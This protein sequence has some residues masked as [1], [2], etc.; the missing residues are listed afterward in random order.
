M[1][2]VEGLHQYQTN[3]ASNTQTM[4]NVKEAGAVRPTAQAQELIPGKVF[5]GMVTEIKNG[6][7][8]LGLSDGRT[9]S[10]RMEA[11]VA[12]E[13]GQPMLFEV[14]ANTGEQIAI[15]PV[16]LESAQNPTLLKALEAAGLK[17]NPRNLSMVNQMMMEQLPID[18][19]SLMQM[20]R[21]VSSFPQ[22][23]MQTL[24]QMQ[25]LGFMI[26]ENSLNQFQN[27]Q[28][29]QQAIL[30]QMQE[31]MEGITNLPEQLA[32][33]EGV[34]QSSLLT[35][36]FTLNP[37]SQNTGLASLGQN[38]S[39]GQ[40][41]SL[42][43]QILAVLTGGDSKT[44]GQM[45]E[46][47]NPIVANSVTENQPVSEGAVLG[48]ESQAA[49][50]ETIQQGV[51]EG[52]AGTVLP[53]GTN[54]TVLAEGSGN[55]ESSQAG[56]QVSGAAAALA[57]DAGGAVQGTENKEA[58]AKAGELP[59]GTP[60]PIDQA[61]T[62]EQQG[63]L[64]RM[65]QGFSGAAENQQLLSN[66]QLNTSLNAGEML[67]QIMHVLENSKNLNG[68]AVKDLF[69]S[70]EWKSLMKQAMAEQWTLTPEQLKEEGAVKELYQ[71]LT[72]QMTELQQVL[73]QT[74][75]EGAAL[76]KTAQSVQGNLEFM[77]QLNQMYTYVQLPLKL[78][79]QNA[80]SDLYVYTNKKNLREKEGD[81]SALLHL[82]LDHLGSTDIYVKMHGQAV[83][84]DFYLADALS[85]QLIGK[86]TDQLIK[87]LEE[88]GYSCEVKVENR[89]AQ[90]NTVQELF[91]QEK[92]E[93]AGK[94]HR[95]SFDVK[96]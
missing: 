9:I 49:G 75:K 19:N 57:E 82:D 91:E 84:T 22:A 69:S 10:A 29:G 86:F 83:Q 60:Q 56:G 28:N 80:H 67:Q 21:A 31:L 2:F 27:Y 11:G 95:Y 7:V 92:P 12:L 14:K 53:E 71:R 88:K 26:T 41:M 72:R 43:Q 23:D 74:G 59:T 25:K 4:G 79:Q 17:V 1:S 52:T 48:S 32:G 55:L 68:N 47:Q 5:E 73:S 42:Q 61:L 38:S 76:A 3:T 78:R 15:R 66:G 35:E 20:A 65:L 33:K 77:N 44:A 40:L 45:G 30:P 62:K 34:G 70:K 51:V 54:G 93:N 37:G 16:T 90:K 87:R 8:T 24:V 96:A 6:Q 81:L 58:A 36:N 63:N 18:K 13:K 64:V 85:Y 46:V 50:A 89:K 94:L 39:A